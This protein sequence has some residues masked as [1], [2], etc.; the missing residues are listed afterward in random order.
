MSSLPNMRKRTVTRG[1]NSNT[2]LF[3]VLF[4]IAGG[5]FLLTAVLYG[6][7]ILLNT[8]SSSPT[9]FASPYLR[10]NQFIGVEE[11]LQKKGMTIE[12]Q[13]LSSNKTIL[14]LTIKGGPQVIFSSEYDVDWQVSSLHSIIHKL[15]IENKQPKQIDFRFGKPIVKF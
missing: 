7:K 11:K 6:V 9:V 4:S 14:T 13:T 12:S 2:K 5:I 15:T 3:K 1:N 10:Q 8:F